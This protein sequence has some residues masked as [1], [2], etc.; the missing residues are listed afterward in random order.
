VRSCSRIYFLKVWVA[1][2]S[3]YYPFYVEGPCGVLLLVS[4]FCE[5]F[6]SSWSVALA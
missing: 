2:C 4:Q 1:K 5:L 3:S 6:M